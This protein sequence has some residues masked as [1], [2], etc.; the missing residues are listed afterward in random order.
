[1]TVGQRVGQRIR[2]RRLAKRIRRDT[3]AEALGITPTALYKIEHGISGINVER[4][5][6]IAKALDVHPYLLLGGEDEIFVLLENEERAKIAAKSLAALS[7]E[8]S[9]LLE[10]EPEHAAV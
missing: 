7:V 2:Q 4:L 9:S 1:M 8:L 10:G 5:Y 3:F 6:E